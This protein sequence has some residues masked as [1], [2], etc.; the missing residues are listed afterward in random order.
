MGEDVKYT[1][2]FGLTKIKKSNNKDCNVYR[3]YQRNRLSKSKLIKELQL[4]LG[5][6]QNK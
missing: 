2:Y 4:F 5:E 6:L 1:K 3:V